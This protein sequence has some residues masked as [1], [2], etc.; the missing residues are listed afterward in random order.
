[1][2]PKTSGGLEPIIVYLK[3]EEVALLKQDA[4]EQGRNL[5]AHVRFLLAQLRK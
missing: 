4:E 1:M 5:S 2:P 3:P